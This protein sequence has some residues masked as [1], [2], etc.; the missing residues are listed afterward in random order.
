MDSVHSSAVASTFS[1]S[2]SGNTSFRRAA[3]WFRCDGDSAP[4]KPCRPEPGARLWWADRGVRHPR[5]NRQRHQLGKPE[6]LAC[7]SPCISFVNLHAIGHVVA[8]TVAFSEAVALACRCC[9]C[10]AATTAAAAEPLRRAPE[11]LGIQPLWWESDLQPAR[12]FLQLLQLHP[13]LLEVNQWICGR[14]PGRHVQPFRWASGS[15]LVSRGRVE[16]ALLL[17]P[18]HS[19][20]W[21]WK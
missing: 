18:R 5:H 20:C 8:V 6:Q 3:V 13:E 12:K 9:A 1:G 11:S 7:S 4:T 14:M 16:A 2:S 15:L 10:T 19:W 21:L 17:V